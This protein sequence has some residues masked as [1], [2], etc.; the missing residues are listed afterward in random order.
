M[1][2]FHTIRSFSRGD[3]AFITRY[4]YVGLAKHNIKT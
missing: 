1:Q 2:V 4:C 3:M